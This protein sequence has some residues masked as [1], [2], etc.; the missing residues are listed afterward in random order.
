MSTVDA[1]ATPPTRRMPAAERRAAILAAARREFALHG[2]HGAGTAAIAREAGCSEAILYRHFASKRALLL[3]VLAAEVEGRILVDPELV[4]RDAGD[5]AGLPAV[6]RGRLEE[7]ELQITARLVLLA[8]S[9]S[10]DPE[11]GDAVRGAFSA[12]R[13]PLRAV[14]ERAQADGSVRDDVD[15]ESLTWIW[16][17][18]FLVALVRNTLAD[19]GVAF[20]AVEAAEQL[21]AL[22]APP[23]GRRG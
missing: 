4:V 8:I 9:M 17:G 12:I 21:A 5:P 16:H 2:F 10:S 6:L 3:A 22:L 23:D 7:G 1:D 11:M 14:L 20:G 18:L 13:A 15:A 19:D